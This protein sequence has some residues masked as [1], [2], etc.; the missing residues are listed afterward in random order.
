M[1]EGD[2]LEIDPLSHLTPPIRVAA[3]LPYNVGTELLVRWLTPQTGRPSG[4]A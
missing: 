1:I 2:A 3:N 4:K